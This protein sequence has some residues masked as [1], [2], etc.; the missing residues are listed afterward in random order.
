M[1]GESGGGMST[2]SVKYLEPGVLPEKSN[3]LPPIELPPS[4]TPKNKYETKIH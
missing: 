2:E 4:S 1:N 3:S